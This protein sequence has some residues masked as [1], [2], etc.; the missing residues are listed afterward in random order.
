MARELRNVTGQTLWVDDARGLS[1]V[2]P[3]GI[4]VVASDDDRY[5]QTGMTGEPPIWQEVTKAG[6]AATKK[7]NG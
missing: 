1:K 4:Y 7:E 3:D 5:F 2:E 6:K